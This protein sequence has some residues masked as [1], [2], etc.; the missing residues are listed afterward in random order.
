M[1]PFD[2]FAVVLPTY[3]EA[4]NLA[5]MVDA[6]RALNLPRLH[7]IVVDDG[8]PDG[9]GRIAEELARRQAGGLTVIQRAAKLGLGTA[10]RAGFRAALARGSAVIGQMDCDFS[11]DPAAL[12]AMADALDHCDVVVGSRYVAGG[13]LDH[14]WETGRRLLSR[15]GTF[16]SRLILGLR[17]QDATAGFKLWRRETLLGLGL[18]RVHSNGYVFQVEMAYLTQRLGYRAC[19]VP[20]HFEDRRIGQ[21]KMSL[22]IK[23]EAAWRV[24]QVWGLHH[25]LSPADRARN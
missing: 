20:I 23:L 4:E 15:W 18:D 6:L 16:Y 2:S 19:E 5:A 9:T 8:S 12:P 10:Y 17:M 1:I 14:R 7:L 13:G 21:S 3:N 11:H 22:D 25:R 24:W